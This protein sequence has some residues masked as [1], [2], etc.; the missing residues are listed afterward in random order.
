MYEYKTI[1]LLVIESISSCENNTGAMT[2]DIWSLTEDLKLAKTKETK[3]NKRT[4]NYA[5]SK[6]VI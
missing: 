2:V 4:K 3:F 6:M 1:F 5:L